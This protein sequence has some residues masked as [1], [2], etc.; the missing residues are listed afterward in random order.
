[1]LL[2]PISI[3][4]WAAMILSLFQI[5][6]TTTKMSETERE[7]LAAL[8]FGNGLVTIDVGGIVLS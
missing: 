4:A 5:K 2:E 7:V 3:T 8:P 1:L 6:P